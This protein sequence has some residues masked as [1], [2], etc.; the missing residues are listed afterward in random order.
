MVC[1]FT[2]VFSSDVQIINEHMNLDYSE[3]TSDKQPWPI[4]I[5]SRPEELT[6]IP[7]YSE[8]AVLYYFVVLISIGNYKPHETFI[9]IPKLLRKQICLSVDLH[10]HDIEGRNIFRCHLYTC[11]QSFPLGK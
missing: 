9:R 6:F 7:T 3:L 8:R 4:H 11:T 10:D 2:C 1:D 5:P